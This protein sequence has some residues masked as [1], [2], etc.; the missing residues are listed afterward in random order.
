M[1]RIL[2]ILL[3]TKTKT[4]GRLGLPDMKMY[5]QSTLIQIA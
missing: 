4:L 1:P 5:Y 3:K 2:E